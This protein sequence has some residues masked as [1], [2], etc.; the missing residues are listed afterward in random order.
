ML[1]G[2]PSVL[3]APPGTIVNN[4]SCPLV[5]GTGITGSEDLSKIGGVCTFSP[6]SVTLPGSVIVTISG[7]TIAGLRTRTT[8]LA[9]FWLG[10]PAM[11]LLGSVRNK[12]L[13]R[14][15]MLQIVAMLLLIL[16]LLM[17]VGCG[18][19]Y[20]QLTP[21]G[22]YSVLVQGTSTDGTVYSAVVPVQV[23]PLSK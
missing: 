22:L 21:T 1:V 18:G 17:G 3:P 15:R 5:S 4:F 19:G 13:S 20:G 7:C 16:A 10:M 8:I 12:R 23:V 9:A 6:G 11:V 2:H 14:K